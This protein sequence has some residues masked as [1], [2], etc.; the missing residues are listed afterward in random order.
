MFT[1]SHSWVFIYREIMML[2]STKIPCYWPVKYAYLTTLNYIFDPTSVVSVQFTRINIEY[3]YTYIYFLYSHRQYTGWGIV[4]LCE[5]LL[6]RAQW[7][8]RIFFKFV[9]SVI[10]T[11]KLKFTRFMIKERLF[12]ERNRDKKKSTPHTLQYANRVS[13]INVQFTTVP[14]KV[15][16]I[17]PSTYM[18]C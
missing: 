15:S 18:Y 9:Y 14:Q 1:Y 10:L 8:T 2:Y 12:M 5:R 17:P 13:K 6:V 16:T 3:I 11:C 4:L 7:S